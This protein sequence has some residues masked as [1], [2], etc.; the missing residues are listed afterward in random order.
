MV[1]IDW[2]RYM[3][4]KFFGFEPCAYFQDEA[5]KL[6]CDFEELFKSY[7]YIKS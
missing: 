5:S 3:V 7:S 2:S 4:I 6:K 1:L